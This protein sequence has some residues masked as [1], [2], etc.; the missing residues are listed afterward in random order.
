MAP[1][2]SWAAFSALVLV[3]ADPCVQLHE[4]ITQ[5]LSCPPGQNV[6]R[7][8]FA[9]FGEPT[10]NCSSGFAVNPACTTFASSM[11]R[12]KQLCLGQP[13]CVLESNNA[14]W[15]PDPCP[16]EPKTLTVDVDCDSGAH[17]YAISFN[18]TLGDNMVLQQ[19]PAHAAVF[20]LVVGNTTNVTV[21]VSDESGSSYSVAAVVAGG[22]WK[23]LLEPTA[24]GGNYTIT[25][26]ATC[27]TEQTTAT[28]QNVTFGD[29]W[30]CAGQSNMA[31]P[32]LHTLDRNT[33]LAAI[34]AGRYSNIRIH[35]LSGN[36]NPDTPWTTMAQAAATPDVFMSFSGSCYYF[37][38]SLTDA[39]GAAAPPL[40]LIHT[41]WGG[42]TI[43]QWIKNETLNSGV[44][45]N[46]SSGQGNDGGWYLSRVLPYSEMTIKGFAWYQ[47]RFAAH[48][49]AR[50]RGATTSSHHFSHPARTGENNMYSTFGNSAQR[51]G[52]S[53]LMPVLVDEWRALWSKT[54]GTTSPTAPFGVVTLAASGSE[55]GHNLG[56]IRLAQTGSFGV[57][58]N[59]ALPNTFL[60][61]AH[62]L[63]DPFINTT[64]SDIKCCPYDFNAS[65][66]RTCSGCD[67]YCNSTAGTQW[68]MGPI[69]VRGWNVMAPW[70]RRATV[71]PS[72]PQPLKQPRS[73]KPVGERLAQSAA[74]TVYG[75]PGAFTGP[76]LSGC[77]VNGNTVTVTFSSELLGADSVAVQPY[78]AAYNNVSA[79]ALAVL[80]DPNGFCYQSDGHHCIDDGSGSAGPNATDSGWVFVDVAEATANS[81]TVDLA[82]SGG[83]IFGIR[84][85]M[86]DETCCA[87]YAP[88]S[89]PCPVGSCP[90]VAKGSR[91]PANPFMAHI[92][93]G[94]CVCIPPQVCDE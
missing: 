75:L 24:A 93:G 34:T 27:S 35:Q 29:I 87:H 90:L 63:D 94:R 41:A 58:P 36:M 62:D 83:A 20:G 49:S 46:S 76:T 59:A 18:S 44:C 37:G 50:E 39:L 23:A 38:E 48:A 70:S 40:G 68:F 47:G 32:L 28:I 91:L 77:R 45:A 60:V 5:T 79:S 51:T 55:G 73:K 8:L 74:V 17:C 89:E 14:I 11:A 67:G 61:Q 52:Y 12:A 81:I 53:C 80:V 43:Q 42:S 84:Y 13:S 33:S 26:T 2:L 30:F 71:S 31:L 86:A 25:A 65:H 56:S 54:P 66:H 6:Y 72:A 9:D 16:G 85:A 7:V 21:T 78:P 57:L 22:Q 19:Q 69:H 92:V 64:C 4:G 82:R 3:A 1:R 15:G 88:S 10:G